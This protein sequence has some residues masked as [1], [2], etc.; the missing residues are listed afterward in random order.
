MSNK[1]LAVAIAERIDRQE[2]YNGFHSRLLRDRGLVNGPGPAKKAKLSPAEMAA[3]VLAR[4]KKAEVD[5][6]DA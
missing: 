4:L 2:F 3:E 6:G 5:N 1:E